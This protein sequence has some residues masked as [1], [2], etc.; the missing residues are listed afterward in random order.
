VAAAKSPEGAKLGFV[1]STGEG[2]REAATDAGR[3]ERGREERARGDAERRE[4]PERSSLA[5]LRFL[6]RSCRGSR[7]G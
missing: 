4:G 2:E 5:L 1:L 7:P 6:S 3:V